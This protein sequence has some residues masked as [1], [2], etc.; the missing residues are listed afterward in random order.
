MSLSL[1]TVSSAKPQPYSAPS[2][3]AKMREEPSSQQG[4]R[5]PSNPLPSFVTLGLGALLFL[6]TP[7]LLIRIAKGIAGL[8]VLI[9]KGNLSHLLTLGKFSGF[10]GMSDYLDHVVKGDGHATANRWQ[11]FLHGGTQAMW[12]HR[13][14]YGIDQK[15]FKDLARWYMERSK[16]LTGIEIHPGAKLGQRVTFDHFGTVI[17]QTAEVGNDVHFVGGVVLG[18]NPKNGEFERHPF[19]GNNI[20]VGFGAKIIGRNKIEDG[21]IIGLHAT[22]FKPLPPNTTSVGF[23]EIIR[24]KGMKLKGR[25]PIK[26]V[27]AHEASGTL[28]KIVAVPSKTTSL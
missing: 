1:S 23:N 22:L 12:N 10:K 24:W 25:I 16:R 5:R 7:E 15:G 20:I 2:L 28:D 13:I 4:N 18:G 26:V 14:A 8:D 17:G 3:H 6:H 27:E 21:C 9:F 19:L 11:A